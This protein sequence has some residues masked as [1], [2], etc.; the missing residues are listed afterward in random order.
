MERWPRISIVTPSLNQ[1]EYIAETIESVIAQGY[2][3]LEHIVIDGGS[4]DG[5]L[6]ILRRYSHLRVISEPDRGHADA[7]N[8][9][10]KLAT[11]DIW[12][13][14]NS[15]D[16][17]LPGALHRVA[18]EIDPGRRRSIVMGR[19]RF[20]DEQGR[21]IGVEHPSRFESHRRVLEIWKGHFIPQPAVLWTP[22]VWKTC[23]PMDSSLKSAWIDYDLFCKFSQKYT[24]YFI[25][26][27]LAT[28][29]LHAQAQ[30]WRWTESQRLE[31]CIQLSRRH[32]GSPLS[33]MYWQLTLS[34]A[35]YRFNRVGRGRDWLRQA[36]TAWH[37]R[38]MLRAI[39]YAIGGGVLAPEVAFYIGVYPPIRD[40][41]KGVVKQALSRLAE[42]QGIYPQTS[43]YL[44]YSKP[45]GDGWAGPRVVV[46]L[47]AP[48]GAQVVVVQGW[49]ELSYM[50]K[51]FLL[52]VRVDGLEL[53]QQSIE[54]SGDFVV[55]L[56]LPNPL[57]A[58][59]HSVEMEAS[60]WFVPHHFTRN[61]DFRPLAW[62]IRAVHLA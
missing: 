58:D 10:F 25:D 33:L 57:A 52:T 18:Q 23:G 34:L 44:E 30:T 53:G 54:R 13:Y 24:F 26:Q 16:T 14:L 21:F 51:P 19:C 50:S 55:R 31:D 22:E 62:R 3:N 1:G 4:T 29:R 56:S 60:S 7:V 43:V 59:V 11:G 12:G 17:L 40:R 27:V 36:Q 9:G 42:R 39:P 45:W 6:A 48:P 5:T 38:Q 49:V 8:K 20:V 35:K 47:E 2:P 32:W 15:D 46:E 41:A 28:Y 37:H 61:G